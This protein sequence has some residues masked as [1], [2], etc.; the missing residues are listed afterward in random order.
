MLG[1][2]GDGGPAGAIGLGTSAPAAE[3]L[4]ARR[5]SVVDD[6]YLPDALTIPK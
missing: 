1:G 6:V 5:C 4:R 3:R 2:F